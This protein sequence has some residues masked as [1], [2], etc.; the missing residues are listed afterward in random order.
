MGSAERSS[1]RETK[2]WPEREGMEY[3]ESERHV[4]RETGAG[5]ECSPAR[6]H[7]TIPFQGERSFLEKE[8][9]QVSGKTKWDGEGKGQNGGCPKKRKVGRI[10]R[11]S[12]LA[13]RNPNT[14]NPV[15][16]RL[17]ILC[18]NLLWK[19]CGKQKT[20]NNR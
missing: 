12:W 18:T 17:K 16:K 2:R 5:K 4:S 9:M 7:R 6:N 1:E 3:R 8:R 13:N 14:Q 11:R 20:G 15:E 10:Q 19:V